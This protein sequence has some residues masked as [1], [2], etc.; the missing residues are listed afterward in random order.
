M[1]Y[2]YS[3]LFEHYE[4]FFYKVTAGWHGMYKRENDG[5]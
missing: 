5:Y 1:P 2:L 4:S 3:R